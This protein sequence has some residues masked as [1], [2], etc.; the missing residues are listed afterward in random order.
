MLNVIIE[1]KSENISKISGI[2][3]DWKR[4]DYNYY[5]SA[6]KSMRELINKSIEKTKYI[7]LSY[8]NEGI[9]PLDEWENIFEPY[10]F[11]K[12]EY[13]YDTFK[14]SKNLKNRE[15]KVIEIM[16]LISRKEKLNIL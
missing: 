2:P 8:N 13:P 1:G 11:T 7:I 10:T 14:G 3:K 6:I 4:S 16:Y 15:N 9:I 5:K 12:Y